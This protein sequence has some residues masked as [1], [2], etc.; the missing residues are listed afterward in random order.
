[1]EVKYGLLIL[2]GK[3]KV[4]NTVHV[5]T[6]FVTRIQQGG[7]GSVLHQTSGNSELG[8]KEERHPPLEESNT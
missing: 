2:W 5:K 6:H 1:M 8:L 3:Y 4:P 7:Q